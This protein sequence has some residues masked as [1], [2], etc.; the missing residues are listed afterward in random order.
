L[1]LADLAERT[2]LDRSTLANQEAGRIPNHTPRALRDYAHA[3]GKLSNVSLIPR[4]SAI[5]SQRQVR[6]AIQQLF[7]VGASGDEFDVLRKLPEARS[8]LVGVED[9]NEVVA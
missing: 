5:H 1:S 9:P 4:R 8:L 2:K 7:R 6:H 3:L